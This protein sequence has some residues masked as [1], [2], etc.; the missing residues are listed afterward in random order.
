MAW[1]L[2][3]AAACKGVCGRR[4]RGGMG[5]RASAYISLRIAPLEYLPTWV[6]AQD[7]GQDIGL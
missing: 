4:V 2:S 3:R 7:V 1:L 6:I 5:A